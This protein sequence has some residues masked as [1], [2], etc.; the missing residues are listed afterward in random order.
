MDRPRALVVRSRKDGSDGVLVTVQDAGTGIAPQ[1][2]ERKLAAAQVD[3]PIIFLTGHGD[4]P[5]TVQ[6]MKAG[7]VEFL[8]KPFRDQELLDAIQQ[9]I[10]RDRA[11]RAQRAETAELRRRVDSPNPR[12]RE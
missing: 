8:T 9:A 7:A 12:E 5:M 11:A 6:A 3:L 2:L 10:E 4:I 1:D